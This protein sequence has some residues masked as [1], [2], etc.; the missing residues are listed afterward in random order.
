M[1]AQAPGS[2]EALLESAVTPAVVQLAD[3]QHHENLVRCLQQDPAVD[4]ATGEDSA[5]HVLMGG[6]G[7]APSLA[8]L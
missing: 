4:R 1:L 7:L 2:Y 8:G 5:E 6:D 3:Q